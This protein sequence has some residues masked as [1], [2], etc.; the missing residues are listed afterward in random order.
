MSDVGLPPPTLGEVYRLL[1]DVHELQKEQNGR[2]R[3]L[4]VTTSNHSLQL[5]GA[6]T[7]ISGGILALIGAWATS[8]FGSK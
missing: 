8:F 2:V 5:K 1:Q 7:L 4:E 3:T 6:W